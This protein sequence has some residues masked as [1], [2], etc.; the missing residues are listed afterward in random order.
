MSRPI[1]HCG[2]VSLK[3][4]GR[5]RPSLRTLD[6]IMMFD[7]S[8]LPPFQKTHVWP[9]FLQFKQSILYMQYEKC[10]KLKRFM[11]R[12]YLHPWCFFQPRA[13]ALLKNFMNTLLNIFWRFTQKTQPHD[14]TAVSIFVDILVELTKTVL[15]NS[16]NIT[17]NIE[18]AALSKGGGIYAFTYICDPDFSCRQRSTRGSTRGPRGPNNGFD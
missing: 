10:K 14:S 1:V 15:V 3:Q 13:L 9:K 17:T 6:N 7:A 16:T 12:C 8:G 2:I 5:A 18:T 11:G 4:E